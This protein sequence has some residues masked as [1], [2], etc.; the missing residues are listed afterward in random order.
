MSTSMDRREVAAVSLTQIDLDDEALAE[1]MRLTGARTKKE[2]VNTALRE[3]ASR[4]RRI[5][6][7]EHFANL[8]AGWD[9]DGWR[10]RREADKEPEE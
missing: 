5:A 10:R 2:A 1:A 7:L 8:A 6:D 4:H 3:L 9:Y